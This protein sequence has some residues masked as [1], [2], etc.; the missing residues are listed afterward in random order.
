MSAAI[1]ASGPSLDQTLT[2]GTSDT[3]DCVMAVNHAGIVAHALGERVD[4]WS[5]GDVSAIHRLGPYVSPTTGYLSVLDAVKIYRSGNH[6]MKSGLEAIAWEEMRSFAMYPLVGYSIM[7]TM[8]LC[9]DMGYKHVDLYGVDM[10]GGCRWDMQGDPENRWKLE[11]PIFREVAEVL[12]MDGF[13]YTN[14]QPKC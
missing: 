5:A 6:P 4:W 9:N 8:M 14:I 7:A 12:A 1:Y 13:S 10:A 2:P 11:R 3:Y